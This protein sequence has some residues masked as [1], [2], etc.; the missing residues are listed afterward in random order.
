M[1]SL[2]CLSAIARAAV[3]SQ[4]FN[5]GDNEEVRILQGGEG[6]ECTKAHL[7]PVAIVHIFDASNSLSDTNFLKQYAAAESVHNGFMNVYKE[8]SKKYMRT[9][10]MQFSSEDQ[11]S[12][13][14]ELTDDE[15]IF[16]KM[17]GEI[18]QYK[19]NTFY[20]K[21]IE[22]AVEMLAALNFEVDGKPAKKI[23]IL[24]TDGAP[25]DCGGKKNMF[26][27]GVQSL[28]TEDTNAQECTANAK[29]AG[30]NV[31]TVFL[32]TGGKDSELNPESLDILTTIS[33]CDSRKNVTPASG[34]L[35]Q[36]ISGT[37][38]DGSDCPYLVVAV[39]SAG[40]AY[41]YLE[42]K[43]QELVDS[44]LEN[45]P[46]LCEVDHHV[47]DKQC[48]A[49]PEGTRRDAGDDACLDN[50]QC[51]TVDPCVVEGPQLCPEENMHVKNNECHACPEGTSRAVKDDK[52]KDDTECQ[53]VDPC[54][55]GPQLCPMENMHVKD[56]QCHACPPGTHRAS[57]DDKCEG[58]STCDELEKK[59]CETQ[60]KDRNPV[61]VVFV[62]DVSNSVKS[63]PGA[64]GEA[65]WLKP[66]FDIMRKT[67]EGL[68]SV[69]PEGTTKDNIQFSIISFSNNWQ[70]HIFEDQAS[71]KGPAFTNDPGMID[72][73]WNEYKAG[74]WKPEF[75][76]TK[77][78]GP[79]QEG[80]RMLKNDVPKEWLAK[81]PDA[82]LLTSLITD[83]APFDCGGD[84]SFQPSNASKDLKQWMDPKGT[85]A[86]CMD[87]EAD[88]LVLYAGTDYNWTDEITKRKLGLLANIS[89]CGDYME[90]KG[91]PNSLVGKKDGKEC[92]L[93]FAT[94][95][96]DYR[97]QIEKFV[98][99]FVE[100]ITTSGS[101]EDFCPI[102]FKVME[103]TCVVCA[104]GKTTTK[105]HNRCGPN[106]NCLG[107]GETSEFPV[108]DGGSEDGAG[109][110]VVEEVEVEVSADKH[111]EEECKDQPEGS[112]IATPGDCQSYCECDADGA[113]AKRTQ[114]GHIF[115]AKTGHII[116]SE[117]K[118]D[119]DCLE[120]G[121]K[122]APIVKKENAKVSKEAIDETAKSLEAVKLVEGAEDV[123][124]EEFNEATSS[125]MTIN[126]LPGLVSFLQTSEGKEVLDNMGFKNIKDLVIALERALKVK[127]G[128]EVEDSDIEDIH[129]SELVLLLHA[130]NL[131]TK[132][133]DLDKSIN[134][135]VEALKEV[136][137]E[138]QNGT[139]TTDGAE[140]VSIKKTT[141]VTKKKE[142]GE[143]GDDKSDTSGD[144]YHPDDE[145]G[146]GSGATSPR[147]SL[148]LFASVCLA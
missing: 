31:M 2:L 146:K 41:T 145:E 118:K 98:P 81:N 124:E 140:T 79:V 143:S 105:P 141:T 84:M 112:S 4:T 87:D 13:E 3:S 48:V 133:E 11:F 110:V 107:D 120:S 125:L 127:N 122:S 40:A 89:R 97:T 58:D 14:V 44:V 86:D 64:T 102:N 25:M 116:P 82:K 137:E 53:D 109:K 104:K 70:H 123:K 54:E 108:E 23:A 45:V 72:T 22:K 10:M 47:K 131:S 119:G 61:A 126:T 34:G 28:V 60:A 80:Y 30:V 1:I 5:L 74:T 55:L 24:W 46:Q 39:S 113:E 49:C 135:L 99:R 96:I 106:T 92:N 129:M 94:R 78:K 69:Y 65:N 75:T 139:K 12:V 63:L 76:I 62:V 88:L 8:E 6:K 83:G 91:F 147:M 128:E 35:S 51:I 19:K 148:A 26:G 27:K 132:E 73:V 77:Y 32:K 7:D 20:Q 144:G 66:Q 38:S 138:I 17:K 142:G 115:S 67:L 68:A 18:K 16:E 71:R 42:K 33:S 101:K 37:N 103:R 121:E 15:K 56:N 9:G 93:F 36:E 90:A 43:A 50:T 21:P 85:N 136:P 111:C 114:D 100:T 117:D 29:A 59:E 95:G 52:C 130:A 57:R 134:T